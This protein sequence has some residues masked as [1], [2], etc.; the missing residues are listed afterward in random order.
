MY[1]I[2]QVITNNIKIFQFSLRLLYFN[3]QV[4]NHLLWLCFFYLSFHSFLN[5]MGELLQ[6]ADRKFYGDWWNANNINVFWSSWNMPVHMWAVRHVYKPITERGYSKVVAGIVVFLMSAFFHEYLVSEMYLKLFWKLQLCLCR[7]M[8]TVTPCVPSVPPSFL[9]KLSRGRFEVFYDTA[10]H[11]FLRG[12]T[13]IRP[14][15]SKQVLDVVTSCH[16]R[17]ML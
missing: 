7:L 12:T 11:R 15:Q 13:D 1:N 4:P 17:K 3:F 5:L 2:S 6:F 14:A 16:Y 10:E 9:P 8:Q